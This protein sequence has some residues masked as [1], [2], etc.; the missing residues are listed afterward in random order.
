MS[1]IKEGKAIAG[2]IWYKVETV[3]RNIQKVWQ[4]SITQEMYVA[5]I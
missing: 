1:A 4:Y 3:T 2:D 5:Q